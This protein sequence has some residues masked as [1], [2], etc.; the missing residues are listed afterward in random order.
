MG[1]IQKFFPFLRWFPMGANTLR[2]DLLAGV[3][4]ALVLIPQSMAY[5]QLAGLPAYYGLYAA[6][7][8]VAVAALWGSSN[9]LAT[10]PVAVVSLLTAS[11]LAVFATPGSDAFVALAIML[12]LLVGVIQLLLGVFKLGVIVNFL[13]HPV[14][15]GFTNAAAIIIALSQVSKLFGVPM[16]RSEHFINDIVG[17]IQLIGD[18]HIPTLLMGIGAIAIMWGVKR[19]RPKWPGVLIAVVLATTLSWA[20]GF[21]HNGNAKIAQIASPDVQALVR[22]VAPTQ[23]RINEVSAE[24]A[25]KTEQLAQARETH[26][27]QSQA[28]LSLKYE[29]DVLRLKLDDREQE[30]AKR[31]RALRK[32]AF[33]RGLDTPDG[34]QGQLFLEGEVPARRNDRR[35]AVADQEGRWGRT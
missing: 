12:A 8:P 26:G 27:S 17:V 18:T 3:T 32:M 24:I 7:L 19:Y 29:T 2:A 4:V 13:S 28:A 30:N 33:E 21:E 11:S 14:I 5:A 35:G 9:Q 1:M 25:A 23:Q 31:L 15:V 22:E 6:F 10:G 16:G 34:A 20:I